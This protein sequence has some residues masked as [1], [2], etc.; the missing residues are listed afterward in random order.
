MPQSKRTATGV[1]G[2]LVGLVGLSAI[3]GILVTATVTPAIA[4]ASNT[5]SGAITMFDNLPSYLDIDGLMLP[6]TLYT[7]NAS[8]GQYEPWTKFYDQ[9]RVPVTWNQIAPV[10][11]D[12]ILSSEDPRFYQHGGIDPLG[13]SRALLSNLKGDANV[14]GG[15]SISQQYVKN[16]LVQQCYTKAKDDK[17]IQKC[18]TDA[19]NS[20]GAAGIG[21]KLQEMRYAIA[22]EQR[23]SKTDILLGYLN[24]ANFGGQTYGIEAASVHYFG[25]HAKD[26]TLVQAAT[27]AG[28]VQNPNVYRIDMPGGTRMVKGKPANGQADGYSMTKQRRSYVLGA[29]LKGHKITQAQYDTAIKTP[30]TP[31]LQQ[32]T[33]GCAAT[34]APYFCSYVVSVVQNDPA[35]GATA[36]ERTKS[37][38]QGGLNIYTTLDWRLQDAAQAAVSKYTPASVDS[39]SWTYGSTVVSIE[40]STGRVLSIA[41]NT[42]FTYDK[43]PQ[44][45]STGIVYAGD[46]ANGGSS[47]FAPGSTFKLFT[48]LDWLEQGHS[49]REVLD[50]RLQ[51]FKHMTNS[52]TGDWTNTS[53]TL[54]RN[55]QNE[56]GF[57][58]TPMQFT[59]Q[60][61]N[62]GFFAMA[63]KLD[64]CDIGK[65]ATKLG[66]ENADGSGP[67]KMRFLTSVI[68]NTASVSP[69]AMG[70]AFSAVANNGVFCQ[71][72][73]IDKVTDASGK[74]RALPARTCSQQLDPA[75][76]ATAAYTLQGVMRP[77][78]TGILSNPND[79][80]QLIGKTGTNESTQTWLVGA[81]TAVTNVVWSG[82]ANGQFINGQPNPAADVFKTRY[83]GVQLSY[84]RYLLGKAAM[85]AADQYYPGGSFPAPDPNLTKQVLTNLPNVVGM[86]QDQATQTLEA[87][88]FIVQVGP[89]VDSN[90]AA[91][92]VAAQ[93]P[94]PGMVAGGATVTINPS[95][96]QGIAV[97]NVAGGPAPNAV[98][99]A[100]QALQA[101]GF[102]NVSPGQ[103]TVDPSLLPGMARV[104]GT[105][106]A[107]GTMAN[108]NTPITVT[109]LRKNCP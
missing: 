84:V 74:D 47:G 6:T 38:R 13:T 20:S 70:G 101:A 95:N 98:P 80:T 83:N 33:T 96:G 90:L 10:M 89:A 73:V 100:I 28:M 87:A 39:T 29:M 55:F 88:G 91:G 72:R 108:A 86:T 62:T 105:T 27:L 50:G 26:L 54:V 12:A 68:G 85:R 5:A 56:P 63:S 40:N 7:K 8:T 34:S 65:D 102:G 52:C 30:I 77:G 15:S 60:S 3:A 41:Q 35:F 45:G 58:G 51:V 46:L 64:M 67:I 9:N 99:Q 37:L 103:C 4:V 75:V 97:P 92:T 59:A 16:V 31:N 24:I 69:I 11:F 81:S 57:V 76:A 93:D 49:V 79:G 21:R 17:A 104:T 94:A 53:N 82:V 78:G 32:P 107:A 19:T 2:G 106:P 18:Y 22:L 23:Y 61:L 42:N 44:A 1:L 14:Q 43:Q 25:V 66:V 109:F 36:E 48:L 71:T